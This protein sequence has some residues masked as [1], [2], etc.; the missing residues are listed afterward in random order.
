MVLKQIIR[1]TFAFAGGAIF[2]V[3]ATLVVLWLSELRDTRIITVGLAGVSLGILLFYIG[4]R[5]RT[6]F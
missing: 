2:V 6:P 4:Y 5:G 1:T 3:G